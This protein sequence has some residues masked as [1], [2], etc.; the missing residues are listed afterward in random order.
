[1][2]IKH[3]IKNLKN[4]LKNNLI[5]LNNKHTDDWVNSVKLMSDDKEMW[6]SM[7]LSQLQLRK[8]Q[9]KLKNNIKYNIL[10]YF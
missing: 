7:D 4:E 6:K 1:L 3:Y 2:K 10:K 9:T 8:E 5:S